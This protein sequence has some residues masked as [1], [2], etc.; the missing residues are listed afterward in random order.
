MSDSS[1]DAEYA[2]AVAEGAWD[3]RNAV[4]QEQAATGFW[5]MKDRK[6]IRIPDMGASHLRRII[7]MLGEKGYTVPLCMRLE[8]E[9]RNQNKEKTNE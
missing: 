6:L 7:I 2:A 9:Y 4:I 1:D 3:A 8:Q 5:R